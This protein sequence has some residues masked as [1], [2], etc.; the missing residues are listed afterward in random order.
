MAHSARRQRDNWSQTQWQLLWMAGVK[1]SPEVTSVGSAKTRIGLNAVR[2]EGAN[3]DVWSSSRGKSR[4]AL[5]YDTSLLC[6]MHDLCT[7]VY[8]TLIIE[9]LLFAVDVH[10]DV[11][12]QRF[13]LFGISRDFF[14]SFSGNETIMHRHVQ[15]ARDIAVRTCLRVTFF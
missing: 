10:R 13:K 9:E 8:G 4:R 14:F 11:C 1:W 7:S 2:T 3:F 5:L 12:Q 6:K 15:K